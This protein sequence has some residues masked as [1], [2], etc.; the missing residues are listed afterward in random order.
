MTSSTISNAGAALDGRSMTR[1]LAERAFGGGS[2][3]PVPTVISSPAVYVM[4]AESAV[5][6]CDPLPSALAYQ[7]TRSQA[8][9]PELPGV[10]RA[11]ARYHRS[12][13]TCTVWWSHLVEVVADVS[14]AA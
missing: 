14:S 11:L 2:T 1:I 5:E 13:A 12:A 10:T 7:A 6:S 8:V 4:V 3:A 9:S